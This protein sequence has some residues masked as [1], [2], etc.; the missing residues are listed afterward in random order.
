MILTVDTTLAEL[1]TIQKPFLSKFETLGIRTVRDLLFHIPTRYDDFTQTKPIA[2][3]IEGEKSTFE[4][5]VSTVRTRKT[6]KRNMTIYEAELHDTTGVIRL[7]WFN[8][9][10]AI[11][12]LVSESSIRVSG[13]VTADTNGLVLVSPSFER[14]TRRPTHTARLVPIYPETYGLTSKFIRWQIE[15]LFTKKISLPDPLPEHIRKEIH[16]PKLPD[17]LRLLHFPNSMTDVELGRKRLA[18]DGMFLAQL[19]SIEQR[20]L[21]SK[22]SAVPFQMKDGFK[23]RSKKRFPFSL[24]HVQQ[25][26]VTEILHDLG[27]T[28][29]MNRLINGDVGSGKTAVAAIASAYVAENGFQVAI[30]APTEVLAKQHFETFSRFFTHDPFHIALLTRSYHA[31]D[32]TAITKETLKNALKAGLVN[33]IIGTHAILQKTLSF[34]NLALVIID[35]QHRFGVVQRATLQEATRTIG[36]GVKNAI[37][38]LLTLTATPIPRT[39]AIAILG[40]L[41]ISIL[42]ELPKSR[43]PITTKIAHTKSDRETVFRFARQEIKKGHQIFIILPLVEESASLSEVKAAKTEY[44][45]LTRAVFPD[46]QVGLLHGRMKASEKEKIMSAFADGAIDVLVSTAVVEVGIDIPNATVMI[47]ENADRFGLSQLHQFR[48]RVGRGSEPSFCFLL[49]GKNGSSN[50]RLSVLAKTRDGFTIAERDMEIRGPGAF[51]GA[52]QSGIPDITMSHLANERLIKITRDKAK[53]LI[54]SNPTLSNYPL[55]ATQLRQLSQEVHL[56]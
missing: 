25:I 23:E 37:P 55:L 45:K 8:Q 11:E 46:F 10:L 31:L 7:V 39:L 5:T 50:E 18:F 36:D 1:S 29:P 6:W 17:T 22:E 13:K 54:D 56:E 48:G 30:L 34:H 3:A 20:S 9:K 26:A 41:D 47:I 35:E 2:N 24:T 43:I 14:S 4:G 19:K 32:N 27:Q 16:L 12:N 44:E 53:E 52:R 28:I 49:T 38:H 40:N 21:W 42:D 15:T 51:F 33:I